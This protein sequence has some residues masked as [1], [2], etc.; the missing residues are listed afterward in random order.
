M[1]ATGLGEKWKARTGA[2]QLHRKRFAMDTPPQ[3][4]HRLLVCKIFGVIFLLAGTALLAFDLGVD[5]RH[6]ATVKIGVSLAAGFTAL[7]LL[8]L[9][10][11]NPA[12]EVHLDPQRRELRVTRT[13]AAGQR[14][15][16]LQRSFSSLGGVRLSMNRADILE[17]DGSLLLSLPL[18]NETAHLMI[19][20]QLRGTVPIFA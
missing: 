3:A 19:K 16:V 13:V 6:L 4:M 8:T 18:A 12:P 7:L 1:S 10:D 11:P 15:T 20:E 5:E 14:R 9:R 2:D 17:T